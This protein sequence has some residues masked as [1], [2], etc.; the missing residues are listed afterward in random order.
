MNSYETA[1]E[2]CDG[3]SHGSPSTYGARTNLVKEFAWAVPNDEAIQAIIGC[4]PIVE[5]GAGKGYWASLIVEAGGDV[6][7]YDMYES[8]INFYTDK[9]EPYLFVSQGSHEKVDRHND[10][11]LF[12]CWPCYDKGWAAE[13]LALYGG[14]TFIYVGEGFGGCTGDDVF[15]TALEKE[16][17]EVRSVRIPQ[18][19]GIHDDLR[20]YKRKS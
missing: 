17:D 19:A 9:D 13:T 8:D 14:D 2:E 4:G 3:G 11:A 15:H 20:I 10:R 5:I 7:A 6:E 18:W 16:W 12:L 1:Y